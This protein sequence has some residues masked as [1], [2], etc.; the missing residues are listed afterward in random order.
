V[1]EVVGTV[2]VVVVVE[3]VVVVVVSLDDEHDAM[4]IAP[5][6]IMRILDAMAT[7]SIA[8]AHLQCRK[9]T[10]RSRRLPSTRSR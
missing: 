7:D 10:L 8:L 5:A 9:P 1:V 6:T 2:V 3:V 4:T